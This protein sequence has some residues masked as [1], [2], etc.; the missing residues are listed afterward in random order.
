MLAEAPFI[1]PSI[2][3]LRAVQ[4]LPNHHTRLAQVAPDFGPSVNG[5]YLFPNYLFIGSKPPA[6]FWD[7]TGVV[8]VLKSEV[9]PDELDRAR[10]AYIELQL[11]HAQETQ[12]GML[13]SATVSVHSV[14]GQC[15][16]TVTLFNRTLKVRVQN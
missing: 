4:I 11:K 6:Y 14:D 8:R 3:T 5:K 15:I 7:F 16:A 13:Q 10:Q 12:L 2:S 1:S 9:D